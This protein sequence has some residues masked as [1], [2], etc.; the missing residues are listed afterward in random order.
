MSPPI[1]LG[2]FRLGAPI[3]QGGMGTVWAAV[4]RAHGVDVAIKVV[5]PERLADARFREAFAREVRAVAAM[6][7]PGIV[8]VFDQGVVDARAAAASEG[9]LQVGSPYLVMERLSEGSL[10]ESLPMSWAALRRVL[11]EL[12]DALAHAHARGLVHRDIKPSNVMRAA[13]PGP[14]IRLVDFGIAH[15]IEDVAEHA[16]WS[17]TGTPHYM[18]PEQVRGELRRMGPWTDLYAV[19]CLAYRMTSGHP[20]FFEPNLEMAEIF[21]RHLEAPVP[22]L[23][24]RYALPSG[25]ALWLTRMLAKDPGARIRRAA[26]AVAWLRSLGETDDEGTSIAATE[27]AADTVRDRDETMFTLPTTNAP[28]LDASSAAQKTRLAPVI[29]PSPPASWRRSDAHGALPSLVGAGLGLYGL[30]PIPMVDRESERDRLWGAVLDI[31]T[32][33]APRVMVIRGDA[34]VGKSRLAGWLAH[35]AHEVGAVEVLSATHGPDGGAADGLG[36]MLARSLGTHALDRASARLHTVDE[37]YARGGELG[38]AMALLE[39]TH[40]V[41]ANET[42]TVRLGSPRERYTVAARWIERVASER[43][44][45]V[46]LDDVQ[47]GLD[48]IGL[49]E[50]LASAELA[51][52]IVLTVREPALADRPLEAA[53]LER[54]SA[55]A[56][57]ETVEVEPLADADHET[58][59]A[60]LLGL[61]GALAREV[62][63]RTAGNPLFAVQL[64]GDW[65]ERGALEVGPAGFRRKDGEAAAIPDDLH[66]LWL[67]RLAG[68]EP[69]AALE[70]AAALGHRVLDTE[71][72][73]ACARYGIARPDAM[74]GELAR[75]GL[76]HEEPEGFAFA[77]GMLVESLSRRAI[78]EGREVALHAACADAL[79]DDPA[80][81]ERRA[82]HLSRAGRLEEAAVAL[83]TA[84]DQ[85]SRTSDYAVALALLDRREE[86]LER[87]GAT[88]DDP[89]RLRGAL[90]RATIL[91]RQGRPRDAE[92]L[93]ERARATAAD[94]ALVAD[95]TYQRAVTDQMAGNVGAAIDWFERARTRYEALEDPRGVGRCEHGVAE[96]L[97]QSGRDAAAIDRYERALSRYAEVGDGFDRAR[98]LLGFSDVLLRVDK[99]RAAQALE[100]AEELVDRFGFRLGQAIVHLHQGLALRGDGAWDAAEER[101]E[102]SHA[103][104]RA[105]GST[106]EV[107]PLNHIGILELYREDYPAAR[108]RFEANYALLSRLGRDGYMAYSHVQLMPCYAHFAQWDRFDA[109]ASAAEASLARSGLVDPDLAWL[110]ELAA[111]QCE[112]HEQPA[113]AARA[114]RLAQQQREAIG[115]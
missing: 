6:S 27:D 74:V 49:A 109:H 23:I 3:G 53:A 105:V 110:L 43:P 29:R 10:R 34:G 62:R 95:A 39:L 15:A 64:V 92:P 51:A 8:R 58:L 98:C 55:H 11:L 50:H 4:H 76:V 41:G 47:W 14:S 113:R 19:G 65:V 77:H 17:T 93:V 60:Q 82:A 57:C 20:P 72:T 85:R 7:H 44:A 13:P 73:R 35:R 99:R 21:M 86:V 25:F 69:A 89:S 26:D 115:R 63:E 48:A 81:A 80:A 46:W 101:F 30:R 108:A 91:N 36:P 66:A 88:P 33:A 87:L 31:A 106:D 22:T 42:P 97:K 84:S 16:G 96:M 94:P 78:D 28:V 2:A 18:A 103:L 40:P 107:V 90:A 79:A 37:V 54:I 70:L 111:S 114:T 68:V 1:D 83:L 9:A 100:E 71:W 112:S 102:R 5:S 59:V 104:L 38:D 52:L 75:R 12:L 24:S 67:R 56:R 32:N 45:L 61:S